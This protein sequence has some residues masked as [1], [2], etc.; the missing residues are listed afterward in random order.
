MWVHRYETNQKPQQAWSTLPLQCRP[1]S[2]TPP[3]YSTNPACGVPTRPGKPFSMHSTLWATAG[4]ICP[5]R[6]D[7]WGLE[8][9]ETRANMI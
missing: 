9:E 1:L 6:M 3:A 8:I 2:A 5:E 7:G 4:R